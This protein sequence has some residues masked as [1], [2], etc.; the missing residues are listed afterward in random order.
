MLLLWSIACRPA[1][2]P[3]DCDSI[4]TPLAQPPSFYEA[5]PTLAEIG[6]LPDLPEG[7][8]AAHGLDPAGLEAA[9]AELDAL[10]YVESLLV[11]RDGVLVFERYLHGAAA[12]DSHNVHSASKSVLAM[13][14]GI[15]IDDG[16]LALDTPVAG[17]LPG[18]LDPTRGITVEHLLTMTAGLAWEEDVTEYALESEPDW[19]AA[20]GALPQATPP[21]STF[22]YSTGQSHL[23]GAALAEATGEDLCTFAHRRLLGPLGIDAERWGRDPQGFF[24]GGYNLYLSP[25]ELARFGQLVLDRGA[26]DGVALVP[27]AWVDDATRPWVEDGGG[28]WYGYQYWLWRGGSPDVDIAWGYGGQLVYTIPAERLVVVI[29]TDTG[30]HDPDYDGLELVREHVLGS[31][32]SP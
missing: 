29:T 6:D 23:L 15:A 21:G 32:R 8:P 3:A 11:L 16:V 17:L 25:R 20:I 12:T 26:A 4:A 22:A 24:S 13:L 14:V 7:T 9:A 1:P 27:P 28:W 31:V 5:N 10:P 18:T 19:V 2:L 30:D